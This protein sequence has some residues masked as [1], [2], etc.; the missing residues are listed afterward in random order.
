M[1]HES[2]GDTNRNWCAQ[3][4]HQ[5]IG[6]GTGSLGNKRSR[7]DHPNYGIIEISQNSERSPRDLRRLAVTQT[8]VK[9]HQL[10]LM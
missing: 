7:G 2:D 1:E 6:T 4:S 8:S 5:R 3:Y 9:D 10:T